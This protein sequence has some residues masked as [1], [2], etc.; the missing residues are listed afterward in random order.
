M[1]R[2]TRN[3]PLTG[4]NIDWHGLRATQPAS[5]A[6]LKGWIEQFWTHL[7]VDDTSNST[8]QFDDPTQREE[9]RGSVNPGRPWYEKV[10]ERC[11]DQKPC[12]H[13][14]AMDP[15]AHL[16]ARALELSITKWVGNNNAAVQR[17]S[18]DAK[19]HPTRLTELSAVV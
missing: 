14:R 18:Y 8:K 3:Q 1:C 12:A 19:V 13:C 16:L 15:V 17:L 10:R 11:G 6:R 7:C 4:P 9:Q 5:A 2:L